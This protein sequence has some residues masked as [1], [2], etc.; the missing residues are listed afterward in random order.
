M[1]A[2]DSYNYFTLPKMGVKNQ[3]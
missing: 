1:L 3:S 2:E